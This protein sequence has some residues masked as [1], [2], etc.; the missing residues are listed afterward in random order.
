MRRWDVITY[1][2]GLW[3]TNRK[4]P[5]PA[6]LIESER[7]GENL[8]RYIDGLKRETDVLIQTRAARAGRLAFILTTPVANIPE[9]CPLNGT[10]FDNGPSRR[11]L[12]LR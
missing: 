7:N 3:D 5:P 4:N 1:N 9:C 10:S 11:L 2:H 12:T 8:E 6:G